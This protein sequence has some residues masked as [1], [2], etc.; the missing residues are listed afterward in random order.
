MSHMNGTHRRTRGDV[1]T[2][3]TALHLDGINS[4]RIN[5]ECPLFQINNRGTFQALI[6]LELRVARPELDAAARSGF[7]DSAE[8][9]CIFDFFGSFLKIRCK[10][11]MQEQKQ[12]VIRSAYHRRAPS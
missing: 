12:R 5:T 10:L 6:R 7:I 3:C 11:N 9:V 2:Y 4:H 8:A 1:A